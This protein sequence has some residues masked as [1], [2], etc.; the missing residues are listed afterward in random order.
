M[1]IG[2][3]SFTISFPLY[4]EGVGP[5]RKHNWV[6]LGLAAREVLPPFFLP[7]ASNRISTPNVFL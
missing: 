1:C 4:F 6:G 3:R 2:H 5:K 7:A